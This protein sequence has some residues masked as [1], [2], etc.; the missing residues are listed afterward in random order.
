MKQN[1][2][3]AFNALKKIGAPV[4]DTD[5]EGCHFRISGEDN[6]DETWADYY[7]G[8]YLGWDFGVNPKIEAILEK[9]DLMCEWENPGVLG[10]YDA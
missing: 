5:R 10:V 4:L 1:A 9:H 6:G 3:L 2:R 8:H 7:D